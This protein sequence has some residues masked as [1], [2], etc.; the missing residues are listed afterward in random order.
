MIK[1]TTA[2]VTATAAL[3][4]AGA[5]RAHHAN[6]MFDLSAPVWVKGTVVRYQPMNPHTIFELAVQEG[7]RA[8]RWTVEGPFLARLKRM[9]VDERFLQAGDV[10]E[11]CGFPL[12]DRAHGALSFVHGHVLLLPNGQLRAWGPYGKID[13]CVRAEDRPRQWVDLLK[14]DALAREAWCDKARASIPTRAASRELVAKINN[15]LPE[16]CG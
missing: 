11:V 16:L 7:G 3:A 4:C 14:S 13:N 6:I 2:L 1:F 10:V 9:H 12:K 15:A 5:L 8:P